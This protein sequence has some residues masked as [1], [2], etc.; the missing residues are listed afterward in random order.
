M[1]PDTQTVNFRLFGFRN[2]KVKPLVNEIFTN[3]YLYNTYAVTN[4]SYFKNET[5]IKVI[6]WD[7]CI[8]YHYIT[9]TAIYIL[10]RK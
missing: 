8:F 7:D 4:Y 1:W 2:S 5:I 9:Y 3:K 10:C 6:Q